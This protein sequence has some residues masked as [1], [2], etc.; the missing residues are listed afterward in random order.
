MYTVF[1]TL[2]LC[3]PQKYCNCFLYCISVYS[4]DIYIFKPINNKQWERSA[5]HVAFIV[6]CQALITTVIKSRLLYYYVN[7]VDLHVL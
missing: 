6:H 7:K 1:L 3:L 2:S 5:G 4:K